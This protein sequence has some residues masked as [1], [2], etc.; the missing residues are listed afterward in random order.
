M[1][2]KLNVRDQLLQR[3]N[4]LPGDQAS[5]TYKSQPLSIELTGWTTQQ[6]NWLSVSTILTETYENVYKPLYIVP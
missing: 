2:F 5:D 1:T 4:A 3:I 6:A